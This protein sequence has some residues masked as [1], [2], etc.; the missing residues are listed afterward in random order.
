MIGLEVRTP[1]A[2]V[3]KH[4]A[5][6]VDDIKKNAYVADVKLTAKNELPKVDYEQEL[7]YCPDETCLVPLKAKT[8]E[9]A[10]KAGKK[11]VTCSYCNGEHPIDKL[12]PIAIRLKK[13]GA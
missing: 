8:I 12:I 13:I 2:I 9:N 5:L 3:K 11:V 7:K 10:I 1:S 4:L 6:F